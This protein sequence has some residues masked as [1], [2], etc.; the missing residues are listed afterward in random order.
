MPALSSAAPRA[1]SHG[2]EPRAATGR[3]SASASRATG[4]TGA[5][6]VTSVATPVSVKPAAAKPEDDDLYLHA[7]DLLRRR[8]LPEALRELDAFVGASPGDP[9]IARAQFW[10]GELLFAE[11]Q[12][13]RALSAYEQAL[14]RDSTGDRAAETLLRIA[15]CHRRLGASERARAALLR[16]RTQFPDSAAAR[17]A[18]HEPEP[19]AQEDT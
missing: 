4:R 15:R 10:R 14:L 5:E 2:Q 3:T 6:P 11:H 19:T 18:E 9:R 17:Q 13:A 1:G 7:L 16:L 12:F 8:E